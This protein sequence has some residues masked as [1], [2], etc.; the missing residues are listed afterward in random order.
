[1][2]FYRVIDSMLFYRIM[3]IACA[4]TISVFHICS[5]DL[6][7]LTCIYKN[8]HF[9]LLIIK[10]AWLFNLPCFCQGAAGAELRWALNL[11]R[12][13]KVWGLV[14]PSSHR[15]PWDQWK[16]AANWKACHLGGTGFHL[17]KEGYQWVYLPT[18]N[19][20]FT[21]NVG[22]TYQSHVILWVRESPNFL[23]SWGIQVGDNDVIKF[24]CFWHW[25]KMRQRWLTQSIRSEQWDPFNIFGT[26]IDGR[27]PAPLDR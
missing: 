26:T 11:T 2:L 12:S 17:W 7:E 19:L 5:Q 23:F 22:I 10:H 14:Y 6:W 3:G 1:M 27:N 24:K 4:F 9:N 16:I 15:V 18:W 20:M 21:V 8:H 13:G 25:N